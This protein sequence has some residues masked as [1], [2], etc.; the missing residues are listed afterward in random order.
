M[1]ELRFMITATP[2]EEQIVTG[3]L[4]SKG[5]R[6]TVSETDLVDLV[7][8]DKEEAVKNLKI[9][10]YSGDMFDQMELVKKTNGLS[11]F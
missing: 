11:L 4:D 1:N 7:D 6:Y 8:E 3:Y 2:E 9:I 5:K 10:W